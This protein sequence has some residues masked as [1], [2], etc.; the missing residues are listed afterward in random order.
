[1]QLARRD[2]ESE[3]E[4]CFVSLWPL[5]HKDVRRCDDLHLNPVSEE[6]IEQNS[7]SVLESA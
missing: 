7:S 5:S 1:M 2:A 6:I 3:C 4:S